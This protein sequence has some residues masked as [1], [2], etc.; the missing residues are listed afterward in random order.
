MEYRR[1]EEITPIDILLQLVTMGKVDP[2]N[3]D[4]VDITEKYIERI[5][6]MQD[7]D[8]RISARAILAASILL[9][10]KT[11][12]LLYTKE[13]DGEEQEEEERIR[14]DVDPYVPPLR[15]AERYYTLDDLIEAL[16]DALEET[17]K[18]K[19]KKKKEVKIEEEIFV[20][21]DFRVD[22]EKHVNK[23][24]EIVR[25]L[26]SNT[27]DKIALWELVFDPSPKIVARTFLYL[28]F[29]ANMGK[30]ELIQE[31]PFGEIFVVPLEN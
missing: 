19:P 17:E 27:K 22:I 12:A 18:R 11:E 4:I 24:Y 1:E 31:E 13:D 23:L 9:R 25:E 10:M 26:Y 28:L 8:L 3:I 29:L 6:E 21:D 2:W 20:V 5:R 7:L 14:V 16:M 30:I 15:R